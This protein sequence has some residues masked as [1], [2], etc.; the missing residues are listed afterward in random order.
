MKAVFRK[1]GGTTIDTGRREL[2]SILIYGDSFTN[3]VESIAWYS[4]DRM[5]SADFR[6]YKD[7]T[8]D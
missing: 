7:K 5:E 2:P 6:Y 1:D 3:A 4:F 8:L